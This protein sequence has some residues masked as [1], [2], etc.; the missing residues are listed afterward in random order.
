[1]MRNLWM[2]MLVMAMGAAVARAATPNPACVLQGRADLLRCRSD[3]IGTFRETKDG[4]R[5]VDSACADACRAGR[6]TC[7]SPVY[8]AFDACLAVCHDALAAAKAQCPPNGDPARDACVDAAQVA[9]FQ[10]RDACREN[11][12]RATL[13]TCSSAFHVCYKAC[14][15]ASGS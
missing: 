8:K 3:C 9:A 2:G 14:P 6:A 11:L 10:C 15:P 5:N 7:V 4:C 13:K 1:M 12:D